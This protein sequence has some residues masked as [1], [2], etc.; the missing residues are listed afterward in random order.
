MSRTRRTSSLTLLLLGLFAA[1]AGATD[2]Y[3]ANGYGTACKAMAGSC[4]AL[5]LSTIAPATNPAAMVFL[6]GRY[7]FSSATPRASRGPSGSH[8]ETSR[9]I[10]SSSSFRRSAPTGR[11]PTE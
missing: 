6:G 9:A 4:V 5:H 3:F 10:R 1:H 11:S 8:R 2:G 7:D